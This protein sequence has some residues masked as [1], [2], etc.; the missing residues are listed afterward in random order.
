MLGPYPLDSTDPRR[1]DI[2]K[3]ASDT[4]T[5]LYKKTQAQ[6]CQKITFLE[7][8]FYLKEITLS[9]PKE[10]VTVIIEQSRTV[11]SRDQVSVREIFQLIGKLCY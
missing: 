9:L 2:C 11:L 4:L 7:I 3:F 1:N 8:I 10:K 6:P 5:F